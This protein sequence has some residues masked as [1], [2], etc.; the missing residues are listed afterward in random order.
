MNKLTF[1]VVGQYHHNPHKAST[2]LSEIIVNLREL[3][4]VHVFDMPHTEFGDSVERDD[5][6]FVHHYACP[7]GELQNAPLRVQEIV[8][9]IAI[10]GA[11]ECYID[12]DVD[13]TYQPVVVAIEAAMRK[14]G[15]MFYSLNKPVALRCIRNMSWDIRFRKY[16]R[17]RLKEEKYELSQVEGFSGHGSMDGFRLH[18]IYAKQHEVRKKLLKL[19]QQH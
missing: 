2:M 15:L 3:G 8:R 5:S 13:D 1:V 12:F 16:A 9:D 6:L 4:E 11:K 10:L 7:N 17:E 18:K 14:S 19:I